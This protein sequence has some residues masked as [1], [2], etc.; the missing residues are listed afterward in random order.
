[1]R[2]FVAVVGENIAD[3]VVKS[4]LAEGEALLH[5]YAGGGPANTAVALGRL[6]T[7]TRFLSRLPEGVLGSLFIERLEHAGVDLALSVAA[8]EPATLAITS[9]ENDGTAGYSFYVSETADWQWRKDELDR[10]PL[11]EAA[12]VHAGSLALA[13]EPGGTAIERLLSEVRAHA[14]VSIDPNV[15]SGIVKTAIYR[16]KIAHWVQLAD[17]IRLSH[18]DFNELVDL[19]GGRSM[20]HVCDEWHDAGVSLIVITRGAASTIVSFQGSRL[21]ISV[22]SAKIVDTIGAGDTFNAGMLHWL[23]R[24][25]NLG[26]R[27]NH[28]D[29]Q[30]VEQAVTYGS[31][32]ATL[33]CERSGANSPWARELE[34]TL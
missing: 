6:G 18:E 10:A 3:A 11:Y 13:I 32:V 2:N 8:Q 33:S 12:C 25:G 28:L 14:T 26:G 16:S 1:M 27:L 31:S 24:T 34:T 4:R 17:I 7:P 29:M 22:N 21:E 20:E 30:T 23:H 15:R 5:V 9:V 19:S